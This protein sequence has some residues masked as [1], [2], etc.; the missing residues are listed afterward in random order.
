MASAIRIL[1]CLIAVLALAAIGAAPAE[2]EEHVSLAYGSEIPTC[3]DRVLDVQAPRTPWYVRTDA[4]VL[5][6][7]ANRDVDIASFNA[8]PDVRGDVILS[9][10]DVD[11]PFQLGPRILI[12]RTIN[13][14]YQV[15]GSYFDLAQ[16]DDSAAVGDLPS[17]LSSPFTGFGDP[18]HPGYFALHNIF[19]FN[20]FASVRITSYLR[21][22]EINLRRALPMPPGR[23]AASFLIGMR[24]MGISEGFEY[25][26]K[27]VDTT[28]FIRVDTGNELLGAQIGAMMEFYKEDCWWIN[29]EAKG[30]ICQNSANQHTT[31][32][33]AF[34]GGARVDFPNAVSKNGTAFVGDLALTVLYRWGEHLAARFGYQAIWVDRLAL[35]A[36]NFSTDYGI[37]IAGPA[38]LRRDATVV[39]HGPFAGLE[40]AW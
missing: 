11:F 2:G 26:T 22:A 15:E 23:A 38:Q 39:Y 34:A 12:G 10:R 5:T 35:A 4:V 20:Y 28:N 13:E 36:D 29:F 32:T 6:R 8:F 27:S 21:N 33:Q 18:A 3:P 1:G 17:R 14:C 7:D 30:A 24:Y 31:L 25:L 9:T 19:D 16:S 37:L 40:L